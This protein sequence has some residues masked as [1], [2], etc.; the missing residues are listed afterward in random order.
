MGDYYYLSLQFY[1]RHESA[2]NKQNRKDENEPFEEYRYQKRIT[3]SLFL[4]LKKSSCD[5]QDY[6]R[7]KRVI[8]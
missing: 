1:T 3:P 2:T 8:S 5:S 6:E 7:F 4:S